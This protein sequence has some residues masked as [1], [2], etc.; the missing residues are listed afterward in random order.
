MV[1]LV[2]YAMLYLTIFSKVNKSC[3]SLKIG[4]GLAVRSGIKFVSTK[5]VSI[6]NIFHQYNFYNP[7]SHCTHEELFRLSFPLMGSLRNSF[8]I[9]RL[10]NRDNFQQALKGFM[11]M[12][13]LRIDIT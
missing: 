11:T 6:R 3:T 13:S 4:P 12:F 10:K 8:L 1:L 9:R 7:L 5:V 2:I